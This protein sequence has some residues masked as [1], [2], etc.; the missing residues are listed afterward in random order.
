MTSVYKILESVLLQQVWK[1]HLLVKY[2]RFKNK[3]ALFN[4]SYAALGYVFFDSTTPV[5]VHLDSVL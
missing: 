1:V 3:G 2:K 4:L 5:L